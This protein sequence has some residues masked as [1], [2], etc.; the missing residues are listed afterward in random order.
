MA[1]DKAAELLW[2]GEGDHEMV[3][4][5]LSFHLIYQPLMGF[6]VL[7]VGTMPVAARFMDDVG[8]AAI[9]TF[10]DHG[11]AVWCSTVHDSVNDLAV[12]GRHDLTEAVNILRG[13]FTEDLIYCRHGRVLLGPP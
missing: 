2:D 12:F 4:W 8:L 1:A 13:V 11:S 9:F 7:A 10:V 3:T 5:K 6:M